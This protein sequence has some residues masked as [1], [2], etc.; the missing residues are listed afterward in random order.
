MDNNKNKICQEFIKE[1]WYVQGFN[2]CNL[3]IS[4]GPRSALL[5]THKSLGYGHTKHLF[6]FT[7]DFLEYHYSLNDFRNIG[8]AFMKR[9]MK[10]HSYFDSIIKKSRTFDRKLESFGRK[11]KKTDLKKKSNKEIIKMF[12]EVLDIDS[13]HMGYSHIIE[14]I[15]SIVDP[16]IEKGLRDILAKKGKE[17]EFKD[18]ITALTQPIKPSFVNAEN[19]SIARIAKGIS[20][21]KKDLEIIN[22]NEPDKAFALLSKKAQAMIKRHAER[23]FWV[24]INFF[25]G[26]PLT[27]ADF[28]EEIKKVIEGN[29]DYAAL[30]RKEEAYKQ[31]A[32]EKKRI[33]KELN[34]DKEIADLLWIADK[35]MYWQD[36]RKKMLITCVYYRNIITKELSKRYDIPFDLA[37]HLLA[38]EIDD[39]I[40]RNMDKNYLKQRAERCAYLFSRN[41]K[42]EM[43]EIILFGK[44]LDS[45]L[46]QFKKKDEEKVDDL[47]GTCAST[48]KARGNVRICRTLDDIKYFQNGEVLVAP[49]TRPEFV[50]AM[51]K[52]V[53]IVTDEGGITS[54]AAILSREL[55]LPCIIGTKVATKVLKDGDLVDV[56]ANHGLVVIIERKNK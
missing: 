45:F 43:D 56:K 16:R 55:G 27:E 38:S 51:K 4:V 20:S 50:P 25:N 19:M 47:R 31:N 23:Y 30:V 39:K 24:R 48:G 22:K 8:E 49:M 42:G 10:N 28:T 44:E 7:K 1:P 13:G 52:A 54:H 46:A 29:P 26:E 32:K 34:L 12:H 41:E 3:F 53:A 21:S 17:N 37:K 36:D 9:Q 6:L 14:G 15:S 2:A 5:D 18:Y 40:L 35:N 33:I 11:F